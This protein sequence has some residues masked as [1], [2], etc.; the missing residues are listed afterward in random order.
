LRRLLIILALSGC[1]NKTRVIPVYAKEA[2]NYF[3]GVVVIEAAG[4]TKLRKHSNGNWTASVNS[5][6]TANVGGDQ[7][8][9]YTL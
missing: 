8:G 7:C 9:S 5:G 1:T 4:T 3:Q 2:A 6:I